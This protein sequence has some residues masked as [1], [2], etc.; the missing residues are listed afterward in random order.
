[1]GRRDLR[2]RAA[3]VAVY[4]CVAVGLLVTIGAVDYEGHLPTE[5]AEPRYLLPLLA[6]WGAALAL[7]ARGAGR[8]WGPVAGVLIVA[9]FLAH[10]LFSGLLVIS[11]Y[12]G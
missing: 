5:Y 11:R 2:R 12:Y 9:L 4:A 6:L 3:E 8:R 1:V 7:A 10:D